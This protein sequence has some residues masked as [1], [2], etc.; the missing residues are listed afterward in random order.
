MGELLP[1]FHYRDE[2]K[3]REGKRE[4]KSECH[5][6]EILFS[7]KTYELQD[8]IHS[9]LIVAYYLQLNIKSK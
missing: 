6:R 9:Y 1:S 2:E 4:N 5:L 8:L 3:V 7:R